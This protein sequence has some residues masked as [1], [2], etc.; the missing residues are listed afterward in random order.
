MTM[1]VM[2]LR[3]PCITRSSINKQ[4]LMIHFFFMFESFGKKPLIK[5]QHEA[6]SEQWIQENYLGTD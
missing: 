6:L 5:T 2:C 4:E 3:T 1:T